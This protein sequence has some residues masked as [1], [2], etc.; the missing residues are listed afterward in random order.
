MKRII[1]WILAAVLCLLPACPSVAGG[2]LDDQD[3]IENAAKSVLKL[4][5]YE[6]ENQ[7]VSRYNGT[8]SGF[9]AFDSGKLITNYHVIDGVVRV[10]AADDD[11]NVYELDKVLCADKA[12]DIAILGFKSPTNMKPLDLYPDDTLKRGAPVVA[13]GSPKGLKNTVSTGIVSSVFT[14]D[15]IP[16]IQITAPISPGS[17]GGALFNNDGQVIGVTSSGYISED[18]YGR[19]T[20]AQN[21]NFAVNIAVAQAMYNAWDGKTYTLKNHK[22][23]AKMDFS[24]VYRHETAAATAAPDALEKAAES[25]EPWTCA[26]CGKENTSRYCVECG[27]ERPYWTCSC[28]TANTGNKFC[29]A[30]GT[31]LSA[32]IDKMNKAFGLAAQHNYDSAAKILSGLGQFNSG[33]FATTEGTRA[34]AKSLVGKMFYDQGLYL[35]SRG[36][37]HESI[38][39]AFTKAGDYSDAKQQIEKENERYLKSWYDRGTKKLNAGKYA[40]ARED[41]EK[42]GDYKDAKTMILKSYYIEAEEQY[43]KKEYTKAKIL[44]RQAGDYSDAKTRIQEI[45]YLLA[46][47]A[48]AKGDTATA[49]TYYSAAG[50]YKDAKAKLKQIDDENKQAKYDAAANALARGDYQSAYQQFTALSG[51]RDADKQAEKS[52]LKYIQMRLG[53]INTN[54]ATMSETGRQELESLLKDANR[55]KSVEAATLAKRISYILG[56]YWQ[57]RNNDKAISYYKQAG[58]YPNAAQQ[59]QACRIKK[60][61]SLVAGGKISDAIKYYKKEINPDGKGPA[62]SLVKPGSK[63]EH[64]KTVL[65]LIKPLGIKTEGNVN[66]GSYAQAYVPYV[67]KLEKHFGLKADGRITVSEYEKLQDAIY[68]GMK[69]SK[70]TQLLEKLA[71]LSY[72]SDLGRPHSTYE[73]KFVR[74]VKIAEK[75][76]G[77]KAD[78]IITKYEYSRIMKKKV[79]KPAKPKKLKAK[80]S[81]NTVK[82]TWSAVSGAVKYEI[83]CNGKLVATTSKTSWT[84]KN[85]TTGTTA[86]YSVKA[87]KYTVTGKAASKNVN[88]PRYFRAVSAAKL[89]RSLSKYWGKDVKLENLTL[90]G[91]SVKKPDGTFSKDKSVLKKAKTQSGYTLLLVCH[92]GSSYVELRLENYSDWSLDKNGK[93]IADYFS[94]IK[95]VTVKGSVRYVTSS[96]TTLGSMP[97]ITAS[98]LS[99]KYR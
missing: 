23:S 48:M 33:S 61:D 57:T 30:C 19:N 43:Q 70:V 16:T 73:S 52:K 82:L 9:V 72:L 74:K 99:W 76:L 42:A 35:Q 14:E 93:N 96:W 80:V 65:C 84:H 79:S 28:G 2:F 21:L 51:F 18:E 75:R 83:Q 54:A 41:F 55:Y 38:V 8:G 5:V 77:L 49:K 22:S 90:Y 26:N 53:R 4:Y 68:P 1:A 95:T 36:A 47:E 92:R 17:S 59:L 63:G 46:E 62:Y 45:N 40:G 60:M 12:A 25:K 39:E 7:D 6:R 24:G 56:G 32:L 29:G 98:N 58:T 87:K 44:F 64:V 31:S 67:K 20:N 88:I 37:P 69:S 10:I 34:E 50:D 71:D 85:V 11:D 91:W 15:G 89:N 94:K 97:S 66:T 3:R 86:K 78:G 81:K 13:I 27:A